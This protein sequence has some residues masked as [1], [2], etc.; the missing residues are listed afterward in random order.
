MNRAHILIF[1]LSLTI[2]VNIFFCLLNDGHKC[3]SH[4]IRNAIIFRS[5]DHTTAFFK[6]KKN[7]KKNIANVQM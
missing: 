5:T 4:F 6:N 3:N 7:E 1:S 2:P